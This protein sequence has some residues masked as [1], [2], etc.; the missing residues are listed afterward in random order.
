MPRHSDHAPWSRRAALGAG[1]LLWVSLFFAVA[2][3]GRK[4]CHVPSRTWVEAGADAHERALRGFR[5]DKAVGCLDA[6]TWYSYSMGLLF[7]LA[8]LAPVVVVALL[9]TRILHAGLSFPVDDFTATALPSEL[10]PCHFAR[11]SGP[12]LGAT[13]SIHCRRTLKS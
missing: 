13:I 12:R 6:T 7:L 8:L 10:L 11:Y 9:A 3:A 2:G 1:Y 4:H 5:Y